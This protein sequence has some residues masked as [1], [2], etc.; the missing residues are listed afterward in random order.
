M[1]GRSPAR[2][3]LQ[4]WRFRS[5]SS[6]IAILLAL[7]SIDGGPA[8]AWNDTPRGDLFLVQGA[9]GEAQYETAFAQWS[10]SWRK[11]ATAG[12]LTVHA[13]GPGSSEIA[14]REVLRES[15]R[16]LADEPPRP[17]WL[18]MIGHGTFFHDNAKFNLVGPDMS[19][20]DLAEW[21]RPLNRPIAIINCGSCSAPFLDRLSGPDRVV[22]TATRSGSEQNYAR[23]GQY[24]AEAIQ[25]ST[26]D[27]DHDGAVSLLEAFL[28]ASHRTQ[29]F[30][31]DE[32]R[33][34]TEHALLDDN[35]DRTG[36]SAEF[37]RGIHVTATPDG[38]TAVDGFKAHQWMLA[39]VTDDPLLPPDKQ[40][41]RD[42]L[43][44]AIE[45]LRQR[46]SELNEDD[47]YERLEAY[48]VQLARLYQ[49][50]HLAP[51]NDP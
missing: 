31:Q 41:R 37:F 35:G 47:Y 8:P 42:E 34:A 38:T 40:S 39:R 6:W 44:A 30:Y 29:S 11:A 18:V 1:S 19:A 51:R 9:G 5:L 26:T 15:L 25:T 17:L 12:S 49:S 45:A 50:S 13:I 36:T 48:L 28:T 10:E 21:L 32:G 43:E 16:G 27:I 24:L 33:L 7:L 4:D 23:F 46:K 22:V 2:G 14:D 3:P 20:G